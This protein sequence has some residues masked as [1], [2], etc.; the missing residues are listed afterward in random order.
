MIGGLS[1]G[2]QVKEGQ[3]FLLEFVAC[4]WVQIIAYGCAFDPNNGKIYGP[5]L[6]PLFVAFGVATAIFS[7]G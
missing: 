7:T 2:P 1:W 6:A 5:V 3:A 4:L